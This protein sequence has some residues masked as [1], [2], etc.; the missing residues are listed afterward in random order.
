MCLIFTQVQRHVHVLLIP[1]LSTLQVAL[2]VRYNISIGEDVAKQ[3]EEAPASWKALQKR[4]ML[5]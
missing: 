2:L 1:N 4:A 3:L 5:K